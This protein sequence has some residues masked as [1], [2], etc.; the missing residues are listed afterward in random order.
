VFVTGATGVLGRPVVQLLA[1]NGHEVLGVAR[2]IANIETLRRMGAQPTEVNLFDVN[3]LKTA[4]NGCD[5]ILHLATK[6]PASSKVRNPASWV[7][8]DYLRR[9]VT[10]NLVNAA[11]KAGVG[12]IVYPSVTYVYASSGDR[13][14][15][16]DSALE[17]ASF[18]QSTLAAEAEIQQFAN[19]GCRGI[20][21]RMGQFYGPESSQ[22]LEVFRMAKWGY[23][24]VRGPNDA[25]QSSIWIDDAARAVVCALE[26]APTGI[27]NIVDEEP[28][29]RDEFLSI[30]SRAVGRQKVRRI[31]SLVAK[32]VVGD[33]LKGV[34]S[35]SH[36]ITNRAFK[37]ATG[38]MPQVRNAKDG[39]EALSVVLS[40]RG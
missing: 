18:V 5:A 28:V 14:I 23:A 1:G 29:R 10:R 16:T 13:W 4:L 3:S 9:D 40:K 35:R 38:W 34:L 24:A 21:L 32:M 8:N 19:L 11:I 33:E 20:S 6:I 2:S 31:P 26:Q 36:R 27:Y 30:L 7:E 12:S 22:T 25:Y 15:D 39:W 37:D 17:P